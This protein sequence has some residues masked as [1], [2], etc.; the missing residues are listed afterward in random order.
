MLCL[1]LIGVTEKAERGPAIAVQYSDSTNPAYMHCVSAKCVCVCK[2]E[3]GQHLLFWFH[4]TKHQIHVINMCSSCVQ[5]EPIVLILVLFSVIKDCYFILPVQATA[6]LLSHSLSILH[7]FSSSRS[8]L[9]AI[10][11]F[12]CLREII[13]SDKLY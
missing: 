5:Q 10:L 2:H 9:L 3:C 6:G 4:C 1:P 13:V 7:F 8:H 12:S 11:G